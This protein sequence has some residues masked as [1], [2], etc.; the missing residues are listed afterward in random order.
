MI[1]KDLIKAEIDRVQNRYL[2]ALYKII[3]ALES[4]TDSSSLISTDDEIEWEDFI[5]E[6]YGCLTDAPI[7]REP[8]GQCENRGEME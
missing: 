2:D 6:T 3:K 5:K 1:T 7:E 8:Q 4:P